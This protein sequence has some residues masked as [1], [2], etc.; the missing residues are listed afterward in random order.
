[1][2]LTENVQLLEDT[3]RTEENFKT[4][5][6]AKELPSGVLRRIRGPLA[7]YTQE[8]RNGRR[9]KKDLWENVLNSDLV[10][11]MKETKTF[12]GEADHPPESEDRLE[13][14]LKQVSHHIND[15]WINEDKGIVEGVIDILDTPNGRILDA[16]YEYGSKIGASSRGAGNIVKEDNE[17]IVE[18]DSYF[19]VTWDMVAL[20]SNKPARLSPVNEGL[21]EVDLN[22]KQNKIIDS[23]KKQVEDAIED[24]D[25][26]ELVRMKKLIASTK[27][28]DFKPLL[29]KLE[30]S[31]NSGCI[32]CDNT[33]NEKIE[34]LKEDLK[35]AYRRISEIKSGDISTGDSSLVE[36]INKSLD[37]EFENLDYKLDA[38]EEAVINELDN[39]K[40][41]LLALTGD[42]SKKVDTN[43][44]ETYK[45]EIVKEFKDIKEEAKEAETLIWKIKEILD[46][47]T[48]N[49][50][51]ICNTITDMVEKVSVLEDDISYL[52]SE[53]T[54]LEEEIEY[55]DE[56]LE[57][58]SELM[59]DYTQVLCR[60]R[61]A[62]YT[63]I[64]E[65]LPDSLNI[66]DLDRIHTVIE[67]DLQRQKRLK[68]LN[69]SLGDNTN[70]FNETVEIEDSSRLDKE[71]SEDRRR[72]GEIIKH[73]KKS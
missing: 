72:L 35:E 37:N 2:N 58:H 66:K 71:K 31:I 25:K 64:R 73:T 22:K 50:D 23:M 6:E 70:T 20:P 32:G 61:G 44:P 45:S 55:K 3:I 54:D 39:F 18:K 60:N 24:G 13:I 42:E 16:L 7:D 49:P 46:I 56:L 48:D 19:F 36:S 62:D 26:K 5:K 29:E 59:E 69:V 41:H 21:K 28:E 9:Y 33:D 1:M 17:Q 57:S 10:K 52:K 47:D 63:S 4:L 8:T 30:N 43:L 14:E 34:R 67:R 68:K 12:F 15:A 51:T 40:S 65:Q 53:I 27:N 38:L 11:E